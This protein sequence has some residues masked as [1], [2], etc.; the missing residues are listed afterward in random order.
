MI[1]T[2]FSKKLEGLFSLFIKVCRSVAHRLQ[3]VLTVTGS[4]R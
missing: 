3:V 2:C 1:W 4:S